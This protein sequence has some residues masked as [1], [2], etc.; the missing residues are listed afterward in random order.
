MLAREGV[1]ATGT[2]HT[3][4]RPDVEAVER[5]AAAYRASAH[6]SSLKRR[7]WLYWISHHL[8]PGH[9]RLGHEL[10]RFVN[11]KG[12]CY[13]GLE[14]LIGKLRWE[15]KSLGNRLGEL[16]AAGLLAATD[17][18]LTRPRDFCPTGGTGAVYALAAPDDDWDRVVDFYEAKAE[19]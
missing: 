2:A 7:A 16:Q 13:P 8:R 18:R 5:A 3:T 6:G 17:C 4:S 9:L 14:R 10:E 1:A 19:G 12:Y 11:A 15:A